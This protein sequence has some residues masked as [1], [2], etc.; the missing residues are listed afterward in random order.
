MPNKRTSNPDNLSTAEG[1][2][3]W[4]RKKDS[5]DPADWKSLGIAKDISINAESVALEHFSNYRGARAKDREVTT[6]R[7]LSIDFTLEEINID[8]LKL[9]FG[10]GIENDAEA[11]TKEIPFEKTVTNPGA[12]VEAELGQSPIQNLVVRSS[13]LEDDVT[14]DEATLTVDTTEDT[15][16]AEF[17]AVTSP[18]VVVAAVVTYSAITFVVGQY[19]KIG[20]EILRVSAINGN[21]VT[22][23][24]AQLGTTN[25]VHA[26]GVSIFIASAGDY[27]VNE[28]TGIWAPILDGALDSLDVTEVHLF[29]EKVVNVKKFEIFPADTVE[30]ELKLV[31][32]G[33][34]GT[35]QV[36]GPFESATLKNNG[37]IP[38]GDGSDWEG[39]PMTA[40]VTIDTSGTFGDLGVINEGEVE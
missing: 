27:I 36:Y 2:Q 32:L 24:R 38:I 21:D 1:V 15:E 37:A 12:G 35:P 5:V 30:V 18:L 8:N 14:Y 22:F 26:N 23:Q 11:G 28:T 9:A 10:F 29:F 25:A 6:E 39:I 7:K 17:N 40:S 3:L 33:E 19:V 4:T 16:N 13:S 20:S 31:I 34:G